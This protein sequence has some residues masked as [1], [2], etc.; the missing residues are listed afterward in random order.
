[1]IRYT[2]TGEVTKPS[3]LGRNVAQVL[4]QRGARELLAQSGVV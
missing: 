1:M 4:L 3:E 2:A